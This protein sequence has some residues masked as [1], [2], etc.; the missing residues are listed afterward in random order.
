MLPRQCT[1][2]RSP[3]RRRAAKSV[4]NHLNVETFGGTCTSGIGWERNCM[5]ASLASAPS[6]PRPSNAASFVSS[7]ETSVSTPLRRICSSPSLSQPSPGGH[8]TMASGAGG[9]PSIQKTSLTRSNPHQSIGMGAF[10]KQPKDSACAV[11]NEPVEGCWPRVGRVWQSGGRWPRP[12]SDAV[13]CH[14]STMI[15]REGVCRAMLTEAAPT[16]CAEFLQYG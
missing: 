5:P 1:P 14:H 4:T 2:I 13:W 15:A 16:L 12:D 6:L 10:D 3:A 9:L 8:I 11:D 7:S